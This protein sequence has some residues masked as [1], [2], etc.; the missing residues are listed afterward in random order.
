VTATAR[1]PRATRTAGRQ[2]R[3]ALLDAASRLFAG[4]AL[5]EVSAAEIAREAGAFP[6]QVTYYFGS[7]EALFVEAA[8]R[9]MLHAASSVER[10]GTRARTPRTYF[11]AMVQT[12]LADPAV[13]TFIEAAALARRRPDLAPLVRDTFAR[14]H[15]EG[16][17]ALTEKL[18]RRGWS[19][20]TLPGVQARGFWAAVIG[21]VVERAAFG[22]GFDATSG[23][24][25]VQLLLNLYIEPE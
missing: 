14:L 10:A 2:M 19:L 20:R 25:T 23:E 18:R 5:S 22:E 4:R 7:K 15:V 3:R 8:C 11:G 13:P 6:S 1:Y 21:V 12:A 24:A 17:R 9:S 16:E